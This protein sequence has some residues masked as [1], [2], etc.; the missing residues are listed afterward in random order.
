MECHAIDMLL[1][2]RGGQ[3]SINE[4]CP[5]LKRESAKK[6]SR[7][8]LEELCE[9]YFGVWRIVLPILPALSALSAQTR[10]KL[11]FRF[12]LIFIFMREMAWH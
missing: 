5:V 6:N 8:T 1:K 7:T 2:Q 4:N 12:D 10:I 11:Q 9:W 3:Q